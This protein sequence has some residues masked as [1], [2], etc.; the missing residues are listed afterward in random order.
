M[1]TPLDVLKKGLITQQ[2]FSSIS[3]KREE[4]ICHPNPK[5]FDYRVSLLRERYLVSVKA[6]DPDDIVH[7]F[8]YMPPITPPS[9]VK[10]PS[11]SPLH[12]SIPSPTAFLKPSTPGDVVVHQ[13]PK[14]PM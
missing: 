10:G 12:L 4:L 5:R 1:S 6:M 14:S 3:P 7:E 9:D 13:S 11:T 8:M 2:R